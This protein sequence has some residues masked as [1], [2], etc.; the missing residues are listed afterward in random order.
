[1]P[2]VI[3]ARAAPSASSA[4]KVQNADTLKLQCVGCKSV[5]NN[6]ARPYLGHKNLI[7]HHGTLEYHE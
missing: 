5:T 2:P 7:M 6:T 1:M 4:L 3:A